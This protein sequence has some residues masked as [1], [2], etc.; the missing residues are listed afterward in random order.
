MSLISLIDNIRR[1]KE[2]TAIVDC[3]GSY[4]YEA[5]LRSSQGAASYL[6]D[7]KEDLKEDRVAFIVPPG[8]EYTALLLGI[9]Q[10]GGI[11]VP[12]CV[13]HPDPELEYVIR[14]SGAGI[15][16]AHSD[17]SGRLKNL[18][19]RNG[20]RFAHLE[21]TLETHAG[22][23]PD[24]TQSRRAMIIYTSGTTSRPKGVV[25]T[26]KNI[27]AQISTLVQAWG[28]SQ[29]DHI[30]NVLPLHH[31]H[32]IVNILLCSLYSGAKCELMPKF[33]ADRV[34]ETFV[35][36]D[37]SLFMAVPTIYSRLISAWENTP[38]Q[39][40]RAMTE[41]CEKMR[42][43]VSGSSALPVSVLERWR[44]ISGRVLL[45]RYGMTEIGMALS[46]PLRGKRIPGH[47][48]KP[49]PGVEV[50]LISE[51]NKIIEG[52][53]TGEI[54]VRGP[55]V[56]LEYW[57]NPAATKDAFLEADNSS[58][59]WFKTGDIAERS[60]EDIYRILGRS[61][62]DIIK[63]GGYKISA[64]EIEEVLR[65]HPDV[66]ECAVVG[67]PDSD[68]GE[69]VSAALILREGWTHSVDDFKKFA[70]ESLAPYKVPRE[71]VLVTELPRNQMGK[72]IKP[73]VVKLFNH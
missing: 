37:Y 3:G 34:W 15:V 50:N 28:W 59:G 46:N 4:T 69:R 61:S 58:T 13:S 64:L 20:A 49:L 62:V 9:W 11:A 23:L 39:K 12:L 31:V 65:G 47:V 16:V 44:E 52:A 53:G 22:D 27:Q 36:R 60:E 43:M 48:G 73:E 14:D 40:K 63:S 32:G 66:S 35:K 67:V 71:I 38:Q 17:F 57:N 42:L 33:E 54:I 5:L 70:G 25:T 29:D 21:E 18:A 72:I 24:V 51:D 7:G 6:L 68:L 2:R 19:R 55:G 1:H 41:A 56:F 10:A 45:E 8:F 30:L 26:H